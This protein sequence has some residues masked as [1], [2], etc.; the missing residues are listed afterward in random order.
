MVGWTR[1]PWPNAWHFVGWLSR[2]D[3]NY[4]KDWSALES[5]PTY[6]RLASADW[7]SRA[8]PKYTQAL[9]GRGEPTYKMPL[10]HQFFGKLGEIVLRF[11]P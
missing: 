7:L 6:A 10:A 8:A 9:V 2:A 4:A 11:V 1:A 3:R 5:Q